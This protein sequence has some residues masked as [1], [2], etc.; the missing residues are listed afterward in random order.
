MLAPIVDEIAR[1]M[2]GRLKVGSLDID[3]NMN[4]AMQYGVMS[5]P[6]LKGIVS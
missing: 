4:T 5:V 1:D 2:E 3:E 6:T